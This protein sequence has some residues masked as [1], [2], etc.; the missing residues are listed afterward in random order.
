MKK[1]KKILKVA[2][3]TTPAVLCCSI[4]RS[5]SG[6]LTESSYLSL[7]NVDALAQSGDGQRIWPPVFLSNPSYPKCPS[8]TLKIEI[9]V[10]VRGQKRDL[11]KTGLTIHQDSQGYYVKNIKK[12]DIP[13][14][15]TKCELGWNTC[16]DVSCVEAANKIL[17]SGSY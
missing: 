9:E 1:I 8:G 5:N 12:K 7:E 11:E 14:Q 3:L 13:V 10:I 17:E 2:G 15:E 6:L 16:Y 4:L